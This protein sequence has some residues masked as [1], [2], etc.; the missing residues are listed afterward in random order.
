MTDSEKAFEKEPI[1]AVVAW[2]D[3]AD[4]KHLQKRIQYSNSLSRAP[5]PGAESTRFHSFNEVTYCVLSILNLSRTGLSTVQHATVL[6]SE[7]TGAL[8]GMRWCRAPRE[9]LRC[10]GVKRW[11]WRWW[12]AMAAAL[13]YFGWEYFLIN[14]QRL[15]LQGYRRGKGR[16]FWA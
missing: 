9:L 13:P 12:D 2:V 1:D 10:S 4:P 14:Y 6:Y 15:T 5:I 11:R 3:G 8:N 7:L 16:I